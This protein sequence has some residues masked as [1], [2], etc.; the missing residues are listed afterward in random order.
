MKRTRTFTTVMVSL[1]TLGLCLPPSAFASEVSQ[2]KAVDVALSDGGV[3]VGQIVDAQGAGV[4]KTAVVVQYQGKDVASPQTSKEGY[5]A[6]KG[7][8]PGVYQLASAQNQGTYRLW[9]TGTA[10]PTAQKGALLVAGDGVTRGQLGAGGLKTFLANPLVIAGI[11][12]TAVAVP[13]GLHNSGSHHHPAS[14]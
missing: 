14:P 7:L 6:V 4:G 2:P 10:P 1:A 8:R 11:V 9:A 5:F 13:V 3:L 12:A